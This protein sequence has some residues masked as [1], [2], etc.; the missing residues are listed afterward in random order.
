M[1]D[2][3]RTFNGTI[4][5]PDAVVLPNRSLQEL[6]NRLD[7]LEQELRRQQRINRMLCR[8]IEDQAIKVTL[9]GVEG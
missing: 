1:T 4:P 8:V 9:K 7:D 2:K 6:V 5:E 3:R